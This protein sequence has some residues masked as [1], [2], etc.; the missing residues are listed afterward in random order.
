VH[1]PGG[2]L[3][4]AAVALGDRNK[5]IEMQVRTLIGIV[6]A[7]I[8][9][10]V[11]AAQANVLAAEGT[12]TS[13]AQSTPAVS[14]AYQ[15]LANQA[16][17]RRYQPVDAQQSSV[18]PDDRGGIRGVPEPQ[19]PV[20]VVVSRPSGFD[21][22]EFGLGGGAMLLALLALILSRRITDLTKPAATKS[23]RTS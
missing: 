6:A 12:G 16:N 18:R 3:L 23:L 4:V 10:A 9:V 21:W 15:A 14:H 11:P 19:A 1:L 22:T 5:E 20:T 2:G 8:V 17:E 13:S 7:S